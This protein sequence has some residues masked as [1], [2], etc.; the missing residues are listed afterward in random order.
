MQNFGLEFV[1]RRGELLNHPFY[2]PRELLG[3]SL[4]YN[5]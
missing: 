2:R 3:L 4:Q 1:K 5:K